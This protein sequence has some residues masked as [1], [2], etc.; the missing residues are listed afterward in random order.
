VLLFG[1]LRV[2][3]GRDRL[4]V[5]LPDPPTVTELWHRAQ[6]ELPELGE[7]PE[8]V[9]PAVNESFASWETVLSGGDRVAFLP[10][11]SGG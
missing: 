2:S 7:P 9:R 1:P 3:A 11:M 10:P 6:A 5:S 8:S 4:V